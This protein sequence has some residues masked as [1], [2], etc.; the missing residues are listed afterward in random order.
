MGRPCPD[1]RTVDGEVLGR[2]EQLDP[3]LRDYSR[4]QSLGHVAVQQAVA[5]LAEHACI[6][7]RTV[8]RQA[9]EPAEQQVTVAL[10]HQLPLGPD[11]VERAQQLLR[12]EIERLVHHRADQ[13]QGMVGRHNSLT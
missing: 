10:L 6:P 9:D 8:S 13:P 11:A 1:Q 4:Q 7:H 12:R 3:R 2:H 5:V